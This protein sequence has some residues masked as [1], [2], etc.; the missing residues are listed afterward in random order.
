MGLDMYL[1][2]E[3][4]FTSYVEKD[5]QKAADI[6]AVIGNIPDAWSVKNV[7]TQVMYWRKANAIHKWFVDNVQDGVDNCE[8][9]WLKK[10]SLEALK[11]AVDNTLA[12]YTPENAAKYLPT[13]SGFF[14]GST[15]YDEWYWKDVENTKKLLDELLPRYD[16]LAKQGWDF[17][18]Q[19]SW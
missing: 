8:K 15:E 18:Y 12:V 1:T 10:E 16:E 6:K 13:Q 5:I 7:E 17:Y 19:A 11:E 4:Y 9:F 3:R 2:A 14:F